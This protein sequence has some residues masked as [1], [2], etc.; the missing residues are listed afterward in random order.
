L[1]EVAFHAWDVQFSLGR[2]PKLDEQ[3]AGLL[4]PTLLES[5]AP[6]IYAVGLTPQRG[7]GERYLLATAD[8]PLARWLVRIDPDKLEARRGDAPA[9]MTITG[10]AASLA[11]LI[12]GRCELATLAQSGAVRL[13]GDLAL[14]DRFALIFPR[15]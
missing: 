9:D 13:D 8:D 2:D 10:S 4:L 12:Y 5:N 11:L 3:I 6:R 14:A 15:P 1:A 7:S